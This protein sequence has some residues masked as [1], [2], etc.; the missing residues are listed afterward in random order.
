MNKTEWINRFDPLGRAFLDSSLSNKQLQA[1]FGCSINKRYIGRV[2]FQTIY[3]LVS[4]WSCW[5]PLTQ[6]QDWDVKLIFEVP[7]SNVIHQQAST[8]L[9][10][11]RSP[12]ATGTTVR[13]FIE[14]D[15][16]CVNVK[17]YTVVKE[18]TKDVHMNVKATTDMK[19]LGCVTAQHLMIDAQLFKLTPHASFCSVTVVKRKRFE[20]TTHFHWTYEFNLSWSMPFIDQK[21][22]FYVFKQDPKCEVKVICEHLPTSETYSLEYLAESFLFK[23][24][25]CIPSCYRS[26]DGTS[27]SFTST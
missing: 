17:C 3:D 7:S 21:E 10:T 27:V 16:Q 20:F 22:E 18:P 26:P 24:H 9:N 12:G 14:T 6:S 11:D 2:A 13:Y 8:T 25:E 23:I 5:N 4:S 15:E 19:E 1:I